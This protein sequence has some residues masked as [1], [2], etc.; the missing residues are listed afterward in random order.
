[1]S[2]KLRRGMYQARNWQVDIVRQMFINTADDNY[3]SARVAYFEDRDWD[4]WW[5][6]LHAIEKYLKAIL[7]LN[8]RSAKAFG[9]QLAPLLA[10]VHSLDAR[11][12]PPP[13]QRPDWLGERR[14][15][16]GINTDFLA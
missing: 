6:T 3:V 14:I 7:L 16:D 10:A 11:L 2:G 8:D 1:M 15:L 9:H 5:L 4:F 13:F 12:T